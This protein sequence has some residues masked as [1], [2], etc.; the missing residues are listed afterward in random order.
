MQVA[1]SL[2]SFLKDWIN[3][4]LRQVSLEVAQS[5]A[6]KAAENGKLYV[7][8]PDTPLLTLVGA[9]TAPF[10]NLVATTQVENTEANAQ[11]KTYADFAALSAAFTVDAGEN[12]PSLHTLE[13][14]GIVDDLRKLVTAHIA[15]AKSTVKNEVI[16]FAEALQQHQINNATIAPESA[17]D[18]T[19]IGTPEL[20]KDESFL[21]NLEPYAN[22]TL[23]LPELSFKLKSRS[24]D[25]ITA[26]ACT[27]SAATDK[28]IVEWLSQQPPDYLKTVWDSFFSVE[29]TYGGL[30]F[31]TVFS[32]NVF[33]RTGYALIIFLLARKLFVDVQED[34]NTSLEVYK[35]TAVQYRDYAGVLLTQCLKQIGIYYR[36][37][38]LIIESDPVKHT[39][40]VNG[41]IYKDWIKAGGKPETI[42]GVLVSGER[43]VSQSLIDEKVASF[44]KQWNS[45]VSFF[46]TAS[47]N[48]SFDRFKEAIDRIFWA[49]LA[50][51]SEE[52]KAF[53]L[54]TPN[55]K[56]IVKN[57]LNKELAGLRSQDMADPYKVALIFAAKV[58][59]YYTSAYEILNDIAE[60]GKENPDIDVREAALI[61][62]INY[63]A[64]YLANQIGLAR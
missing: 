41:D 33:R 27:G 2:N 12:S 35:D 61:A 57:L 44:T 36:T 37:K 29:G 50:D 11:I 10:D 46:K 63:L 38:V 18:I 51:Q 58:R 23:L 43:V 32:S 17:F 21:S 4:M 59:F 34:G 30:T 20:L 25:E 16:E 40:V 54:K 53:I 47:A 22:K 13:L 6:S 9:A 5:Y 39:A 28:L 14:N 24:T 49:Q 42:L 8:K 56:D 1:R 64:S 31:Q 15:F 62:A 45:Y 26:L 3:T 48:S 19:S 7:A 60:V 55:F 52:E